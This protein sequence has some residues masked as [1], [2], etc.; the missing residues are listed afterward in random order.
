MY[1]QFDFREW[2]K[3]NGHRAVFV[4]KGEW[5][6]LTIHLDENAGGALLE[7]VTL[8]L[9]VDGMASILTKLKT[10]FPIEHQGSTTESYNHLIK[11]VRDNFDHGWSPETDEDSMA[12]EYILCALSLQSLS[13]GLFWNNMPQV[14]YTFFQNRLALF[15]FLYV[16][17]SVLSLTHTHVHAHIYILSIRT[18]VHTHVHAFDLHDAYQFVC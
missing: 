8:P 2:A 14:S 5:S 10:E 6:N 18:H 13:S 1:I 11:W 4:G 16:C 15:S 3:Q 9:D 7:L 17:V 12:F